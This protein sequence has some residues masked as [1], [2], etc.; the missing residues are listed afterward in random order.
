MCIRDRCNGL[1][2]G[3]SKD[4]SATDL[5]D[6]LKVIST[7][8]KPKSMPGETLKFIQEYGFA[9]NVDVALRILLTL[10]VRVASRE[11]TFSKLKVTLV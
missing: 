11:R 7:T 10:P 3:E 5:Q 4:I 1:T 6:E 2:H 8:V 9:P